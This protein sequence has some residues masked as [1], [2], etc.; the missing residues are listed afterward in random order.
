MIALHH[1]SLHYLTPVSSSLS[2]G[3][4]W[5]WFFSLGYHIYCTQWKVMAMS[6]HDWGPEKRTDLA[7]MQPPCLPIMVLPASF[8]AWTPISENWPFAFP[9]PR[10]LLCSQPLPGA[11]PF[12]PV[13]SPFPSF[14]S[15]LFLLA[16][17]S[18]YRDL[19]FVGAVS[20]FL[21]WIKQLKLVKNSTVKI[22]SLS[23][24]SE[25]LPHTPVVSWL[26]YSSD[27]HSALPALACLPAQTP[28]GRSAPL[29]LPFF[30]SASCV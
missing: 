12:S 22:A 8:L 29:F 19:D 23:S 14:L 16:A 1:Y 15:L 18:V 27:N 7:Q 3:L 24:V 30:F 17:D 21:L 9:V 20:L 4:I 2:F 6:L 13:P 26:L 28:G 10:S 11:P 25:G 5:L